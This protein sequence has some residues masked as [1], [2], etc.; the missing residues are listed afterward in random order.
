MLAA[1]T[2][3]F[4]VSNLAVGR[5]FAVVTS[6]A[7]AAKGCESEK[8]YQTHH[9][10]LPKRRLSKSCTEELTIPD[11]CAVPARSYDSTRNPVENPVDRIEGERCRIASIAHEVTRSSVRVESPHQAIGSRSRSPFLVPVCHRSRFCNP[12]P[13][14]SPSCV[15]CVSGIPT[16]KLED[17]QVLGRA[18]RLERF[19]I[20]DGDRNRDRS[21]TTGIGIG[22]PGLGIRINDWPWELTTRDRRPRTL[23]PAAIRS[24]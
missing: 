2:L 13:H 15:E 12:E 10:W 18:R 6:D 23:A 16:R 7:S 17:R 8:T 14:R 21:G 3:L 4:H 5:D 11:A 9:K 1:G 24:A 22:D 19:G 20:G